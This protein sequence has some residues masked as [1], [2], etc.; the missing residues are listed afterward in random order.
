MGE[1][2]SVLQ[3]MAV[4]QHRSSG[5]FVSVLPLEEVKLQVYLQVHHS[6]VL[7]FLVIRV[8]L[9]GCT[10]GISASACAVFMLAV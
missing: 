5:D 3:G 6:R 7:D 2:A 9:L 8:A 10:S 1:A 4:P